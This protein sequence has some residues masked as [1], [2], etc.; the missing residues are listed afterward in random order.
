M[1]NSPLGSMISRLVPSGSWKIRDP[2]AEC[3]LRSDFARDEQVVV[4]QEAIAGVLGEGANGKANRL[5]FM[6]L[7]FKG[8][9]LRRGVPVDDPC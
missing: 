9:R 8:R 4:A 5:W 2:R 7:C 6:H 1:A 3:R